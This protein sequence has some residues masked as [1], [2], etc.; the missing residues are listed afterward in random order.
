MQWEPKYSVY[1]MKTQLLSYG[2]VPSVY[3]YAVSFVM[4]SVMT[5]STILSAMPHLLSQYIYVSCILFTIVLRVRCTCI[6]YYM[7]IICTHTN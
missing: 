1:Y 6:L 2:E 7:H 5:G 4:H 3:R